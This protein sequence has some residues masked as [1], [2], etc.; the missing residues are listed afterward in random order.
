MPKERAPSE[1][2]ICIIRNRR[3]AM[4]VQLMFEAPV[5]G[6]VR[7]MLTVCIVNVNTIRNFYDLYL[8]FFL[9]LINELKF[10]LDII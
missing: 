4:K 10:Y 5:S 6:A 8:S 1:A 3:L 7:Q 9:I 2:S